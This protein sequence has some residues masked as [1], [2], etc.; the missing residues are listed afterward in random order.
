MPTTI[1]VSIADGFA[2]RLL[3][4]SGVV[5]TLVSQGNKVVI[6]TEHATRDSV[7]MENLNGN[8]FFEPLIREIK[9]PKLNYYFTLLWRYS[10]ANEVS[11]YW[12]EN[13]MQ[14]RGKQRIFCYINKLFRKQKWFIDLLR[15]IDRNVMNSGK[16]YECLFRKYKIDLAVTT[17]DFHYADRLIT[18]RAKK[19][20]IRT[21]MVVQ[22]WDK[23]TTRGLMFEK[24]DYF[25]VWNNINKRD[26]IRHHNVH[27][28]Q[29]FVCGAPHFDIYYKVK[30]INK[31]EQ[32]PRYCDKIGIDKDKKL[33]YVLGSV[34][35]SGWMLTDV[36]KILAEALKENKFIY[37][38]Q[39]LIRPHP[40]VVCGY[41]NGPGISQDLEYYKTL[42]KDIHI[43]MPLI[44]GRNSIIRMTRDDMR[45]R[46]E[47][48]FYSDVNINFYSTISIEAAA[49]DS[50]II[51]V[52]FDEKSNSNNMC[53]FE[54]YKHINDIITTGGVRVARTPDNLIELIND[55]LSNP[56]RDRDG[57]NLIVRN[58]FYKNDGHATERVA[59]VINK[60]A[61]AD[62]ECVNKVIV[63][64]KSADMVTSLIG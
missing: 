29:I 7:K 6:V 18:R 5:N 42:S 56:E 9:Y 55:Y 57:R 44:S 19:N 26:L 12:S 49:V 24:V 38:S 4:T 40:Q 52:G 10:Q 17:T 48:L 33:I 31:K 28:E 14:L 1:L 54:K 27:H 2:E 47:N 51:H 8:V 43:D 25:I 20:S 30:S 21:L 16:Y 36:I 62:N 32:W 11:R 53:R 41:S 22:S 15:V 64:E 58:H 3:L 63:E 34:Q 59:K 60:L 61:N 23:V 39:V 45:G 13:L 37:P 46:A 35:R 50:P